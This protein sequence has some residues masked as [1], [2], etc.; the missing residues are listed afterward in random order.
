VRG[1]GVSI[2]RRRSCGVQWG[3]G[4]GLSPRLPASS[5]A[6][7]RAAWMRSSCRSLHRD[8]PENPRCPMP[9]IRSRTLPSSSQ[10]SD[11]ERAARRRDGRPGAIGDWQGRCEGS[12]AWRHQSTPDSS[13]AVASTPGHPHRQSHPHRDRRRAAAAWFGALFRRCLRN[14]AGS[15]GAGSAVRNAFA[16]Q[17]GKVSAR[18]ASWSRAIWIASRTSTTLETSDRAKA[19]TFSCRVL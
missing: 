14:P 18:L 1:G 4:G 5:H 16:A 17:T 10:T 7:I 2:V 3:R 8:Q 12:V 9:K 15:R 19:A 6:L 11:V 13:A